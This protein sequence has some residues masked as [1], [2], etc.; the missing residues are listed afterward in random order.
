M[1]NNNN[2]VPINGL[3]N[4]DIFWD[5]GVTYG[6]KLVVVY[7]PSE[8]EAWEKVKKACETDSETHIQKIAIFPMYQDMVVIANESA[9]PIVVD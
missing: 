9:P 5:N 6:T 2:R 7:G 3:F 1:N 8:D 4:F